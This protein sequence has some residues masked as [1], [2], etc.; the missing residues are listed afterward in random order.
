MAKHILP[1]SYTFTPATKTIVVNRWLRQEYLL[2]IT[3]TT[4]NTVLYNFSDPTIGVVSFVNS[5]V[6]NVPTT[7]IVLNYNTTS[8]S[9][10]DK[11]AIMVDEAEETFQPVEMLY[12]PVNKLRVSQPQALIDTDFEY[13]T[14]ATKW[15]SLALVNN[16]P[17]AF[18]NTN[19]P[20]TFT[21]VTATNN[22]RTY[23]VATTTPPA[24]GSPVFI[25]DTLFAGADGL[26]IVDSVVGGTSFS[27]TGRLPWTS[28]T[29]SILSVGTTAIFQGFLFTGAAITISSITNVGTLVTVTTG[30]PHGISLG[31]EIALTGTTASSNA[32]NGSWVVNTVISPTVFTFQTIN[33]PTGSITGGALYIRSLGS[34]NHR[35]FDGGVTFSTNAQTHNQQLVRQTRRYF[36]YQSG[37]GIQLSTGT[38]LKPSL[39]VD[40]IFAVGTTITVITKIPHNLNP[41]VTV[42]IS[43]CDQPAYNGS[44]AVTTTVDAYR[45]TYV[46]PTAPTST[47]ATGTYFVSVGNWFGAATR[48]GM[49]DNQNG[50][51]FEY[52]GQTLFAVRRSSTYQLSGQV[53]L[54]AGSSSVSGVT[55]NG[56]STIFS[57]QLVPG[58]WVV[59]KGMSYRVENI[60]SDISMTIQPPYRGP[61]NIGAAIISKTIDL[62]IPQSQWNLDR[63]DGTGPSGFNIDLSRMQ[64]FYMDYSWYGAGS[65][66]WG[67]RG[68]NGDVVYCHKLPN[69]NIN[70][71][72][73]MRSG[74][75]PARYETNTF[76]KYTFLTATANANDTTITVANTA[77]FPNS[78]TLLIRNNSTQEF[79][80]YTA[81]TAT[82][83]T[84][85][86]R[87]QPGGT[88]TFACTVGNPTIFGVST[89]GVQ[90]G[91][92]VT[93]TGIP[94]GSYVVSF[95]TNTSVLLNFAPTVAG[96]QS[97]VFNPMASTAQ[98]FNFSPI[99]P[100]AIELHAPQ[101]ASTISHWG[102]SV[103][104][105]GRF[106]DD[107]SF[108]F[109]RGMTTALTVNTGVTNALMSFRVS[110]SVSNGITGSTLGARE[111]VNRM[112][113]VLRQLDV[114]SNGAFLITLVLNGTVSSA[115]PNWTGIGGSSLAQW[116]PH[117]AGTT[118]SG[119]EVI[120]GFFLNPPGTVGGT[121]FVT[122]QQ[123]LVLVR[124][125]GN[126]ILGG[127]LAAGNA[128]IFPDGPDVVTVVAQNIGA[129]NSNLNA[130]LSW[131]EAQA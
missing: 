35:S 87:A 79:V 64:M 8:H 3:N 65:V 41:G 75:L 74:N 23:T 15:E 26:Y 45:F 97:L 96:S 130:R 117:T 31:N 1:D 9:S 116:I 21:D 39:N 66:R 57:K 84:G 81:K 53:S 62:K 16:R 94:P 107:K 122:T 99:A 114:Y 119:G 29:G 78:G 27:Y 127:G 38:T 44:F 6:N 30:V 32:P 98:T 10:T 89:A 67:F 120:Y 88:L 51:F 90:V 83:F 19:T 77:E 104:M 37:K 73:Y 121:G 131:T 128:G 46:V 110:P 115:T 50:I 36:R 24:V 33:T 92:I 76:S 69:N 106:D 85:L 11:I 43:G 113:M 111:I 12:D 82:T 91:Q 13:G 49:Y 20:L 103:I 109:T 42:I 105:D 7:T 48:V 63:S 129:A 68:L 118:V 101:F 18:F 70:F 125:L 47:P 100:T 22:S 58:D 34:S 59:I 71:E 55:I 60:I 112:Q 52:D 72:A 4:R 61:A 123:D 95:V 56:A 126:S 40:S 5:Q 2:L 80:N 108:V 124:D 17:Y 14:Q 102:T 93:G 28:T 54:I 25:Q 86:I